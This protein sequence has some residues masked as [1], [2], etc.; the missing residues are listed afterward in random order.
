GLVLLWGKTKTFKSFWLLDLMLHVALGWTYR[1]R[2][3]RQGTVVYCAFEGAHGYKG[4]IE[5]LRGHYGIA[6][7]ISVAACFPIPAFSGRNLPG[8]FPASRT[9][10]FSRRTISVSPH[11]RALAG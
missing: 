5:A 4:R 1:D 10:G 6:N 9:D 3:V 8:C 11:T 2:A 7:M